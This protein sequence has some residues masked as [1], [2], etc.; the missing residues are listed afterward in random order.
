MPGGIHLIAWQCPACKSEAVIL[1]AFPILQQ[2]FFCLCQHGCYALYI[3]SEI[4][5]Y[6]VKLIDHFR[7]FRCHVNTIFSGIQWVNV[8]GF[9]KT[10]GEK[11]NE[12][13]YIFHK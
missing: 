11:Q 10:S 5:A 7:F 13:S 8:P 12:K 2:V 9:A 1:Y 4:S 3:T 6:Q